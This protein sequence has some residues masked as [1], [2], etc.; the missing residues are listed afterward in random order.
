MTDK[1]KARVPVHPYFGKG[2]VSLPLITREVLSGER[3]TSIPASG[4]AADSKIVLEG[5][6]N[7]YSLETLKAHNQKWPSKAMNKQ[8]I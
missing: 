6:E 2:H 8:R 7:L 3:W 5:R 4:D 1:W